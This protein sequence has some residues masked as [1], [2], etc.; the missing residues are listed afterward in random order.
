MELFENDIRTRCENSIAFLEEIVRLNKDRNI[1]FFLQQLQEEIIEIMYTSDNWF[2]DINT[3]N[4][5]VKNLIHN[6]SHLKGTIQEIANE[7]DDMGP[8]QTHNKSNSSNS[9]D[10]D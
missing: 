9:Y 8:S 3:Q 10:E 4:D 2:L 7:V 1:V 6:N 5:R